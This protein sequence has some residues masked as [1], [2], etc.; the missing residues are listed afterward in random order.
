LR[1][2]A[3]AAAAAASGWRSRLARLLQRVAARV[4]RQP[5]PAA[6]GTPRL[7]DAQTLAQLRGL[8]G[9][10]ALFEELGPARARLA[11]AR[12]RSDREIFERFPLWIVPTY[13]GDAELFATAEFAAWLP[14]ELRFERARLDQVLC[15]APAAP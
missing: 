2:E 3:G 6:A 13:P 5:A 15:P 1:A 14:A 8:A 4:G 12:R 7:T 11:A 9:F 10:L